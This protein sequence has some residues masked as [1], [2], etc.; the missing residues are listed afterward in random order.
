[1]QVSGAGELRG[2]S[3][4]TPHTQPLPRAKLVLSCCPKNAEVSRGFSS[5]LPLFSKENA[6]SWGRRWGGGNHLNGN[7]FY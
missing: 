3:L 2:A 1:M 4:L 6:L 7:D 5:H